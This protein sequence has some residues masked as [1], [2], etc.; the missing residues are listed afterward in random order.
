MN[1]IFPRTNKKEE[2]H[3]QHDCIVRH[4]DGT[5]G[6]MPRREQSSGGE[7]RR[8]GG[9]RQGTRPAS[10]RR[11]CREWPGPRRSR[12]QRAHGRPPRLTQ[13]CPHGRCWR[14][15]CRIAKEVERIELKTKRGNAT[16]TISMSVHTR[17]NRKQGV[18]MTPYPHT[19]IHTYTHSHSHTPN[20][21]TAQSHIIT[22]NAP[23][24]RWS[25]TSRAC[26]TPP[27]PALAPES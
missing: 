9:P 24:R 16:Q 4:C 21:Y 14:P 27:C 15:V 10:G 17:H 13:A 12:V 26:N 18:T 6:C 5:P 23:G 8:R 20:T 3:Y 2:E 7:F 22:N 25:G 19:H 11:G 1:L